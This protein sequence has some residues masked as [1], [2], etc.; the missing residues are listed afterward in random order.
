MTPFNFPNY[1]TKNIDTDDKSLAKELRRMMDQDITYVVSLDR[2]SSGCYLF[3]ILKQIKQISWSRKPSNIRR[4]KN[5][6]TEFESI[7]R[8]LYYDQTYHDPKLNRP[9]YPK[10]IVR[11]ID[12]VTTQGM[13]RMA[14]IFAGESSGYYN[15]MC[16]GGSNI[17]PEL[18]DWH[19]YV[20]YARASVREAGFASGSGTI[21]KHGAS[22]SI[23]E[24]TSTIYE[25]AA[26]DFPAFNEY[27]TL[28]FRSV[29]DDPVE[30]EQGKD[31]I[32]V[33]HAAYFVSVSDFE[34]ALGEGT[35]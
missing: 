10:Q 29:I 11:K 30:H 14:E 17:D 19:L 9:I 21:V 8:R 24:P 31:V 35:I 4:K 34:E 20:E 13:A 6:V 32:T 2:E 22:F 27:Q 5:L 12:R 26:T 1:F 18:G 25:F 16:Y 7:I 3:D 33:S 15:Y 28:W 23:N